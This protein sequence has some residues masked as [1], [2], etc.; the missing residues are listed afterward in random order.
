M[1]TFN[2]RLLIAIGAIVGLGYLGS[3]KDVVGQ[4]VAENKAITK[5]EALG[6]LHCIACHSGENCSSANAVYKSRKI[7]EFI[8]LDEYTIWQTKDIHSK[9]YA[10]L[11]PNETS[12]NVAAKMQRNLGGKALIERVECLNCHANPTL[13]IK[14]SIDEK[15]KL[16]LAEGVSCEA[17]HGASHDWVGKHFIRDWRKEKPE[18][19]WEK[20][21]LVDLRDPQTRAEK[22]ASC[23]IGNLKEGKFVTHRMFAAGHP[24][25]PA[26]EMNRYR[27]EQPPH[28]YKSADNKYFKTLDVNDRN[29]FHFRPE[30]EEFSDVRSFAV[31]AVVAF[32]E[33]V[34][35]LMDEANDK[36]HDG[37]TFDFSH[38]NCYSCHHELKLPS[39]RQ[40][41]GF[42]ITPGRPAIRPL[43][44]ELFEAVARHAKGD[45]FAQR[46][47]DKIRAFQ[48][49][50]D[51]NPFGNRDK[52]SQSGK[53]LM[54]L[55]DQILD[56]IRDKN[57]L[58]DAKATEKLYESMKRTIGERFTPAKGYL[59]YDTARQIVWG[60]EAVRASLTK[61]EGEYKAG[62]ANAFKN[63]LELQLKNESAA[64]RQKR[65]ENFSSEGFRKSLELYFKTSP[66]IP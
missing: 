20:H 22:C 51:V 13:M 57:F 40:K 33:S 65:I 62:D 60:L 28:A 11:I 17:C 10:A 66:P 36:S 56:A 61:N 37:M 54:A 52:L 27:D 64:D 21:G 19:K 24:P 58:Y 46:I 50:F 23:H 55:S 4:P 32:R 5:H 15:S 45:A 63:V 30:T 35:L 3:G 6:N 53:D 41:A 39:D 42:A 48:M 8:K 9:A 16:L 1:K 38:L 7:D 12:G 14:E 18:D 29:L 59:D 2:I 43:S 34:R 44:R 47:E 26:F 25:L 49:G 31:G